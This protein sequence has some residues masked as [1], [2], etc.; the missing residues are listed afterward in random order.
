LIDLGFDIW[1][2][3]LNGYEFPEDAPTNPNEKKLRRCDLKARH[4]ILSELTPN[5]L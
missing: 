4:V 5:S 2:S 3:V 1:L